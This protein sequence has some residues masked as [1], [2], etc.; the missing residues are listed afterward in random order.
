MMSAG[1]IGGAGL[2]VLAYAQADLDCI[3]LY[4]SEAS[5][6]AREAARISLCSSYGC[7]REK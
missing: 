1:I 4:S 5:S 2:Y 3:P 7:V 6:A